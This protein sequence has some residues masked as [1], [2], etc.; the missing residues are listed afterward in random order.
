VPGL[1]PKRGDPL[2]E[3]AATDDEV[4]SGE[5]CGHSP[6]LPRQTGREKWRRLNE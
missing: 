2:P 1:S 5:V 4:G 6:S 3:I